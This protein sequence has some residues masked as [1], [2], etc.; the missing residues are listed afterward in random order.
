M[1]PLLRKQCHP[2]TTGETVT[3]RA[4]DL[5]RFLPDTEKTKWLDASAKVIKELGDG[6]IRGLELLQL[7]SL[8]G[9]VL[10]LRELVQATIQA[11][12]EGVR[13]G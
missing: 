1:V 8:D 3:S 6:D 11:R 2:S 7:D 4:A 12:E 5:W 9:D 13:S 10:M